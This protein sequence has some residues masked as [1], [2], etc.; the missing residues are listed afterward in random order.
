M[1]AAAVSGIRRRRTVTLS[2]RD[3]VRSNIVL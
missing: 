3:K 2:P 1:V